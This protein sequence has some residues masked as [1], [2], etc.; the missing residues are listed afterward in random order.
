MQG[1]RC[2]VFINKRTQLP[3]RRLF[4][5][6]HSNH[7]IMKYYILPFISLLLLFVGSCSKIADLPSVDS[8]PD[9]DYSESEALADF[10]VILSRAVSESEDIRAFIQ[11]NAVAQVDNDYDVFY[12]FVRDEKIKDQYSFRDYLVLYS[13][14]E[15]LVKIER[16]LPL[17][18]IYVPDLTWIEEDAFSAKNWDVSENEVLV[19]NV[20]ETGAKHFYYNGGEDAV[21]NIGEGIP[22]VPSLVVKNNERIRV[23]NSTKAGEK[24]YEFISP[25]FDNQSNKPKIRQNDYRH[26]GYQRIYYIYGVSTTDISDNIN[27]SALQ[28]IAPSAIQAYNELKDINNAAHRDFC[29]YG[30]N[31]SSS[32]GH[33]N[34]HV[35]DRLFRLRIN[36]KSI[37]VLCDAP[38]AI[39]HKD[40]E[41]TADID[42]NG[43]SAYHIPTTYSEALDVM[44]K[45]GKLEVEM[46]MY[47][48][49]S[50]SVSYD[51]FIMDIDPR[52][53]F[54]IK[55]I[56]RT[57][58][59]ATLIKFY[60]TWV[61]SVNDSDILAKWYYP[62]DDL[63]LP[64]WNLCN[65]ATTVHMTFNE[66]DS[67]ATVTTQKSI[68]H[69]FTI[70]A[71]AKYK[72]NG[73][74]LEFGINPS[75]ES[76]ATHSVSI[77]EKTGSDNMGAI[78]L[79][80]ADPYIRTATPSASNPSYYTLYSYST[81]TITVSF[82]PEVICY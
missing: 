70:G 60:R 74:K 82:L 18:T 69:K 52:D 1:S 77:A 23:A 63:R 44:Y 42:D 71:S 5:N 34:N 58:Y 21:L 76:S 16:A 48:G 40:P 65:G 17:L 35:R 25:V 49:G 75:Y 47:Y 7:N 41:L 67:D 46:T 51:Q 4:I 56:K 73:D 59:D 8:T 12:P 72:A 13:D 53:L 79:A 62:D 39:S 43:N 22:A 11:K 10:A 81:G 55:K 33:L 2:L 19:C 38:S 68:T 64:A 30:M 80:Y 66:I 20:D 14:E 57:Q 37:S 32:V 31:A 3:L 24:A 50:S 9:T 78:T 6:N 29:Y 61:Y 15:S 27:A 36:P 54:E 28:N 26:S 45:G